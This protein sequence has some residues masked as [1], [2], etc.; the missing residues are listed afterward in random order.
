MA[1]PRPT[2]F[3]SLDHLLDGAQALDLAEAQVTCDVNGAHPATASNS[4]DLVSVFKDR[5]WRER[6]L[7]APAGG[8]PGRA[9]THRSMCLDSR[10][11][12]PE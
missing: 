3:S 12:N 8:F 11:N 4:L 5:S 6:P 7:R 1:L 10:P 2:G 9:A